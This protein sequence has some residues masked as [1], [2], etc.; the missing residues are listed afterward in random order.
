MYIHEL[1]KSGKYILTNIG[2]WKL[3]DETTTRICVTKQH[4]KYQMKL[5][6]IKHFKNNYARMVEKWERHSL[7]I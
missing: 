3:S 1:R 2:E 6:I 5:K 7:K 4:Q